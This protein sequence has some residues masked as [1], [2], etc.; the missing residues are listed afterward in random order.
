MTKLLLPLLILLH[1]SCSVHQTRRP[2]TTSNVVLKGGNYGA[3][4]WS[5]SLSFERVSW[6]KGATL[7][8]E[9]LLNS[10]DNKS[11][12]SAWM[13]SDKLQLT[14]CNRFKVALVYSHSDAGQGNSFL[15]DQMDKSG[16]KQ[17]TL[18]D[19]SAQMKAH[20]N[21]LDWKLSRHKIVGLCSDISSAQP[22][23][24]TLP[25]FKKKSIK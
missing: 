8:H 18:L 10:L 7:T 19:F 11:R 5:E 6:F 16:F 13:G 3:E 20:P 14:K 1:I 21:Y 25:G 24:I 22:I 23:D 12:F 15:L 9:V 4:E 2:I 17:V